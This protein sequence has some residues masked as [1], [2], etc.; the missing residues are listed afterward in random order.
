MLFYYNPVYLTFSPHNLGQRR[1]YIYLTCSISRLKG[2][3]NF[4]P[5]LI[6][7]VK[8]INALT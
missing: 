1:L 7:A 5:Y 3:D 8:K 2:E 6:V 4:T